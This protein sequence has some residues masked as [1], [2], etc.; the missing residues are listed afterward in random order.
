MK[1][2][3]KL[4][5][6]PFFQIKN[7]QKTIEVRLNDEKR[8]QL[9][10]GDEIE[11]SLAT[12]PDEKIKTEILELIH[13]S[14]F[15]ELFDAYQTEDFGVTSK[16]DLMKV[17]EYYTKEDELKYGV[18]GIKLKHMKETEDIPQIIKDVGFDFDWSE[19]KVWALDVPA[20]EMDIQ[21][22]TWH[23]DIPFLWENGVYDLKPQEVIDEPEKH[24]EEYERTMKAD[25]VHPIDIME[26]KG[27]WLI[28]DGLHRLIK[29]SIL[30][31]QKVQVRKISQDLIP[32]IEK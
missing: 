7:G 9:K 28:L 10:V 26:N 8:Q 22:L 1:H 25:L 31:M 3:M 16:E 23:F 32:K 24:K 11:F 12:N 2:E 17:Y 19:E 18:L 20:E 29:F 15:T 13:F 4:Q 21:E 27:R 6:N 30:N 5:P 14:T